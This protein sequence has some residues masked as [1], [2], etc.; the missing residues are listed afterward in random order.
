MPAGDRARAL[1]AAGVVATAPPHGRPAADESRNGDRPSGRVHPR[2]NARGGCA[3]ALAIPGR[4]SRRERLRSFAEPPHPDRKG[5]GSR[6]TN[7]PQN[8]EL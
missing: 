2:V 5:R 7:R 4:A 1:L 8:H 6:V 3:N